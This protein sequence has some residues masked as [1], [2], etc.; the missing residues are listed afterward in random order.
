ML[1]LWRSPLFDATA[2]LLRAIDDGGSV[3]GGSVDSAARAA[4]DDREPSP[5]LSTGLFPGVTVAA[6]GVSVS[7]CGGGVSVCCPGLG[8]VA[9]L[10]EGLAKAT[11]ETGALRL[12]GLSA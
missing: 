4:T 11:G 10:A 9:A 7:Q 8:R 1:S 2:S 12:V 5:S 3:G 6:R